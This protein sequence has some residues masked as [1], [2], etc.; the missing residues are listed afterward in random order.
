MNP[1]MKVAFAAVVALGL[2]IAGGTAVASADPVN[3]NTP[4]PRPGPPN[5]PTPGPRNKPIDHERAGHDNPG[6][7]DHPAGDW[8]NDHPEWIHDHLHSRPGWHFYKG[9]GWWAGAV[10]PSE[11]RR[12]GGDP[13]YRHDESDGGRFDDWLLIY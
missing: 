3:T 10:T 2:T 12:A 6:R 8:R 13:D 1:V 4:T 11:C 5:N 7:H 9:H